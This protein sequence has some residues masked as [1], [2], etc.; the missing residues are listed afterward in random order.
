[1][2]TQEFRL[3][4]LGDGQREATI[5]EWYVAPG[6]YVV[7]GQPLLAVET[8]TALIE[9][10]APRSGRIAACDVA[11]GERIPAG[12]ILLR[13]TAASHADAL[14]LAGAARDTSST[15]TD[16]PVTAARSA[17]AS[18][19]ASTAARR[20]AREL[21]H[22]LESITASDVDDAI[23]ADG[24]TTMLHETAPI[25]WRELDAARRTIAVQMAGAREAMTASVHAR[26]RTGAWLEGTQSQQRLIRAVVHACTLEPALNCWFDPERLMRCEHPTVNIGLVIGAMTRTCAPVLRDAAALDDDTLPARLQELRANVSVHSSPHEQADA[27]TISLVDFGTLGVET[28]QLAAPTPQVAIVAAGRI[29]QAVVVRDGVPMVEPVLPLSLS[30]DQRAVDIGEAARFLDA[31]REHLERPEAL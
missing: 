27:A 20:L 1:M 30:F 22:E 19:R 2:S 6:D 7:A 24:T 9:V 17:P 14:A 12:T 26:A 5:L 23:D 31:L 15:A 13:L 4:A 18:V 16:A 11:E 28:A 29:T 10:P 3:P 25:L 21:R 8:A